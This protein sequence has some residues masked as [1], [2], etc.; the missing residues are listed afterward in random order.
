M[1]QR[2][3]PDGR[4]RV[5]VDRQQRRQR[6]RDLGDARGVPGRVGR[7]GVDHPRERPRDAIEAVVVGDHHAIGRLEPPTPTGSRSVAQ[8]A[9]VVLDRH[10]RVDERRI[11]PG[12]AAPARDLASCRRTAVLPVDLGGLSQADHPAHRRDRVPGDPARIAA[13]IPVLVAVHDGLRCHIAEPDPA[14]HVR[15]ALAAQRHQRPGAL[16]SGAQHRAD[17]P[18]PLHRRPSGSG[19]AQQVPERLGRAGG[20]GEPARALHGGVVGAE[21][22]RYPSGVGGAAGVLQQQ[23]VERRRARR[24]VEPHRLGQPHPDQAAALS[25]AA[26]LALGDVERVRQRRQHL[27]EAQLDAAARGR[28]G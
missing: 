7:L 6:D 5:G 25:V 16:A 14:H 11:E 4:H 10:Q 1:Q 12:A 15:S 3:A 8:N 13:A 23:R 27:R 2:R 18:S 20:V 28:I 24:L 26:G 17:V 9:V 19:V 22:R 21:Q